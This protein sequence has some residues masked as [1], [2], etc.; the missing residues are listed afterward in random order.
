[1]RR[2]VKLTNRCHPVFPSIFLR[3]D[4]RC[5]RAGK[6][7]SAT[8]KIKLARRKPYRVKPIQAGKF[9]CNLIGLFQVCEVAFH[10]VY[11]ADVSMLGEFFL[12]FV[13]VLFLVGQ[14]IYLCGVVLQDVEHY[15]KA[16]A[17]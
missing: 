6:T 10:P 5:K 17:R 12:S 2:V 14:E 1:M 9:F 4:P 16:N 8:L 13:R 11:F 15:A 7:C 3:Q